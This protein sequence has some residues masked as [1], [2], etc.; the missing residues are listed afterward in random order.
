MT[1]LDD[2][3]SSPP[4][5]RDLRPA[6]KPV[7]LSAV[8][9]A[10][11]CLLTGLVACTAMAVVGWLA[12]TVG[13]ASGAVRAGALVWLAAHKTGVSVP[14]GRVT[15]A[16][17]GLTLVIAFCLYR[18]G[19][20]AA[21]ISEADLTLD[22]VKASVVLAAAY[23]AGATLTAVLA[24]DDRFGASALGSFLA[25][26]A[27]ALVCGGVG[28]LV[29]SGAA[30]DVLDATPD[31]LRDA[32]PAGAAVAAATVAAAALLVTVSLLAH[33]GTAT[34]L[35][36]SLDP[37]PV[38]AVVLFALCLVLMP[39]AVVY[40]LAFLAG[41]GF[42]LGTGTVVAPTGV[43]L[44]NLP[45]LPLL[46][47]LPEDGATPTY[48]LLLTAVVPLV[49]G[50]VG[51]LV[52]A[53]RARRATYRGIRVG[54]QGLAGRAVL[55]GLIAGLILLVLMA[56]GSGSAGPGR[57]TTV[58]VTDLL[59]ATLTPAAGAVLGAAVTAVIAVRRRRV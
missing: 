20:Y 54:W 34:D 24:S 37:G 50:A 5:A 13:G 44:G 31:W 41:P 12:A 1:D 39:N 7:A 22:L 59:T 11:A 14:G 57:M 9:A 56:L 29:E 26:A 35:L 23:G 32:I 8:V 30:E 42:Q 28:V 53:R 2:R 36:E 3:R 49:A 51:G 55:A 45:A 10:G 46:A 16:P 15:L 18:G 17:L 48:L 19:R 33:F 38:G 6:P 27:L 40:A 4:P 25:A 58:G 47:A 43:E 52:L 21:R